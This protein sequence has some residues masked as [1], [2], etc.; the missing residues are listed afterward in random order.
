MNPPPP[1]GEYAYAPP[2][3]PQMPDTLQRPSYW[4]PNHTDEQHRYP[5]NPY[6]HV[7]PQHHAYPAQGTPY[8]TPPDPSTGTGEPAAHPLRRH[9]SVPDIQPPLVHAYQNHPPYPSYPIP[10]QPETQGVY[11]SHPASSAYMAN[12]NAFSYQQG[13][14]TRD[15]YQRPS[16][17]Q[18]YQPPT[19]QQYQPPSQPQPSAP[20]YRHAPPHDSSAPQ[21]PVP[22]H[23][24]PAA[25]QTAFATQSQM[26]PPN[27]VPPSQSFDVHSQAPP[28]RAV[29]LTSQQSYTFIAESPG[30]YTTKPARKA[31]VRRKSTVTATPATGPTESRSGSQTETQVAPDPQPEIVPKNSSQAEDR[32]SVPRGSTVETLLASG[33]VPPLT[34]IGDNLVRTTATPARCSSCLS[35]HRH[36]MKADGSSKL[37]R[38]LTGRQS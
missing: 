2:P 8:Y 28:S 31:P 16:A 11:F 34:A 37:S 9:Y 22:P 33:F 21:A 18:Q 23:P 7:H 24:T 10:P 6:G 32:Y 26:P 5:S 19:V 17:P 1:H 38:Q 4:G 14:V 35:L 25:F 30:T 20:L 27:P 36:T 3:P 13:G 15:Q 12:H 29:P